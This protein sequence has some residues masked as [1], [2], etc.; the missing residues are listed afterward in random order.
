MTAR[1][2]FLVLSK[3]IRDTQEPIFGLFHFAIRS[4]PDLG[5]TLPAL[6]T[7]SRTHRDAVQ[8]SCGRIE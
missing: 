3:P 8:H 5:L 1:T 7:I 6:A 2:R 4:T